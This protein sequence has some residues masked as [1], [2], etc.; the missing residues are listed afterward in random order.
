MGVRQEGLDINEIPTTLCMECKFF[1]RFK[2]MSRQDY[3]VHF[4]SDIEMKETETETQRKGR[5]GQEKRK[6]EEKFVNIL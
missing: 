5:R 2:N 1:H 6:E 4:N 3:L